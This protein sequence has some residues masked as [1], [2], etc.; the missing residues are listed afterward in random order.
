MFTVTFSRS[1]ADLIDL[2]DLIVTPA[3]SAPAELLVV[4]YGPCGSRA[5]L[6]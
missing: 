5:L 2:I 6:F 4:L 1:T 3:V